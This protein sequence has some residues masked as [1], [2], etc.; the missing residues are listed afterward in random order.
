MRLQDA[1]CSLVVTHKLKEQLEQLKA[2]GANPCCDCV[3]CQKAIR[4]CNCAACSKRKA[5]AESPAQ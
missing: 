5:T 3:R 4:D 1:R 2:L